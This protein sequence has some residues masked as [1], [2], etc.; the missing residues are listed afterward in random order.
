MLKQFGGK[1][2]FKFELLLEEFIWL[3]LEK[4]L[5][6]APLARQYVINKKNR[7]DILG[8]TQEKRLAIV[9]L[10]KN[11]GGEGINQLLR[12]K[13][14]LHQH[15]AYSSV[16]SKVDSRQDFLLIAIAGRFSQQAQESAKDLLPEALLLT[17][18]VQKTQDDKYSLI[19]KTQDSKI[20]SR[21]KINIIEDSLFDSLPSFLQGYLIDN[22]QHYSPIISIVEQIL[23][24]SP[25][26]KSETSSYYTS[27][28]FTKELLFAKYDK[29][30]KILINKVC[31]EFYYYY[32]S[33]NNES[34]LCLKVYLPTVNYD[35]RKE[36]RSKTI[37]SISV[38]TND[39]VSVNEL[40]DINT[41]LSKY[42]N[43]LPRYPLKT[44]EIN[45]THLKRSLGHI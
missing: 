43:A 10:K 27:E 31:A 19:L 42:R 26:L 7:T 38:D 28:G 13:E 29:N 20:Y 35:L 34:I 18:E 24:F 22:P 16:L 41:V 21:V 36:K 2:L 9:E 1:F 45:E 37:G 39:F 17:Y 12:Y 40:R 23:S 5:G 44:S 32:T 6:T 33:I 8:I 25:E 30:N 14:N 11:S 3:N 4:L 15:Y